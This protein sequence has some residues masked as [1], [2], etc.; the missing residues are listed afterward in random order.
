MADNKNVKFFCRVKT[1]FNKRK[2]SYVHSKNEEG[3]FL[4]DVLVAGS[5]LLLL[6]ASAVSHMNSLINIKVESEARDQ[7][8]VLSTTL[9][10]VMQ[11]AGCGLNVSV[12]KVDGGTSPWER[13][14][15]CAFSANANNEVSSYS[16]T[17]NDIDGN[18]QFGSPTL[19]NIS[20][21]CNA[22]GAGN[23]CELGDQEFVRKVTLNDSNIEI[24]YDVKIRYWFEKTGETKP[25]DACSSIN[26]SSASSVGMPDVIARKITLTWANPS[27]S[28]G[29]ES[30]TVIKRQNIPTDTLEFSSSARV[31][32]YSNAD[33]K[34]MSL[35]FKDG[36]NE[37]GNFQV[38]R[39]K[40]DSAK[41]LWFPYID[42]N[43]A[44]SVG[45]IPTFPNIVSFST[46]P[47][48]TSVGIT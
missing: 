8:L 42:K 22:K 32:V 27:I 17:T 24:S 28:T 31:G 29:K 46:V 21:Y 16:G 23:K 18:V 7:A 4:I 2:S 41:C 33:S 10:Q 15:S 26:F 20:S 13:V 38:T 37:Y 40:A 36:A 44:S 48:L 43:A 30:I 34:I 19:A 9:Q 35:K 14:S 39:K 25:S 11:S 3:S 5:I 12:A 6:A 1:I 45:A 47:T